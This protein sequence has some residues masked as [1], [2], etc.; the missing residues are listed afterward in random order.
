LTPGGQALELTE[1][2]QWQDDGEREHAGAYYCTDSSNAI[3]LSL[4]PDM[5]YGD[6]LIE[7][8]PASVDKT[9]LRFFSSDV[10]DNTSR[11]CQTLREAIQAAQDNDY[12]ISAVE[13]RY[14]GNIPA[15]NLKRISSDTPR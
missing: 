10:W 13:I 14:S 8:N 15:Q 4:E 5:R 2:E 12:D 6:V 9:A 7:I 11:E 3:C 1:R